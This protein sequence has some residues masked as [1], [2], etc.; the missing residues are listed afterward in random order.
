MWPRSIRTR[1]TPAICALAPIIVL[2]C[3]CGGSSKPNTATSITPGGVI[4]GPQPLIDHLPPINQFPHLQP[5]SAP[6]VISSP[7]IWVAS[8]GLPGTPGQAEAARLTH[9]GFAAGVDE[10]LGSEQR[11]AVE[12]NALVEE[13]HA[14]QAAKAELRD[15]LAM[16]RSTGRSPGYRFG[17]FTVTGVPGAIGYTIKQ[18]GTTSDAVAFAAGPY[19]Y[20]IQS[21]LPSASQGAISRRQLK[22]EAT[23][24]YRHLRSL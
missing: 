17:R 2:L 21:V 11:S 23:A 4:S 10:E 14:G 7:S 1:R 24:W 22:T 20:L 19:F 3:A 6:S 9:M 18:P 13:F 16:S 8:L 15:R 12:V 5:I